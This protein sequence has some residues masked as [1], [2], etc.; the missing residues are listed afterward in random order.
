MPDF[1]KN[2]ANES[3]FLDFPLYVSKARVYEEIDP[4]FFVDASVQP[5]IDLLAGC[6]RTPEDYFRKACPYIVSAFD[7]LGDVFTTVSWMRTMRVYFTTYEDGTHT[8]DFEDKTPKVTS[9]GVIPSFPKSQTRF[10]QPRVIAGFDRDAAKANPRV[11]NL[12]KKQPTA[13]ELNLNLQAAML[14]YNFWCGPNGTREACENLFQI[15][16]DSF[17]DETGSKRIGFEKRNCSFFDDATL[18]KIKKDIETLVNL[19]DRIT[20]KDQYEKLT[21]DEYVNFVNAARTLHQH[22]RLPDSVKRSTKILTPF[23]IALCAE[24]LAFET[25]IKLPYKDGEFSEL[26]KG[27]THFSV[28]QLLSRFGFA[29]RKRH[30]IMTLIATPTKDELRSGSEQVFTTVNEYIKAK[31]VENVYETIRQQFKAQLSDLLVVNPAKH[32]AFDRREDF[33][34]KFASL[35]S[36]SKWLC[37]QRVVAQ[38]YRFENRKAALKNLAKGKI[39]LKLLQGQNLTKDDAKLIIA[40]GLPCDLIAVHQPTEFQ[41]KLAILEKTCGV[42]LDEYLDYF[43]ELYQETTCAELIKLD[44][45]N[46]CVHKGLLYI[47]GFRVKDWYQ[48]YKVD[49]YCASFK[50]YRLKDKTCVSSPNL[51]QLGAKRKYFP[52]VQTATTH[53]EQLPSLKE[54]VKDLYCIVSQDTD[55]AIIHL[56]ELYARSG[57]YAE[58]RPGE[59][60]VWSIELFLNLVVIVPGQEGNWG[61]YF[62]R[63]DAFSNA[64][65]HVGSSDPNTSMR[66]G[67]VT[68]VRNADVT[69]LLSCCPLSEVSLSHGEDTKL[70]RRSVREKY[71]AL[72]GSFFPETVEAGFNDEVVEKED[73]GQLV[74]VRSCAGPDWMHFYLELSDFSVFDLTQRNVVDPA[75]VISLVAS[76]RNIEIAKASASI[77]VDCPSNFDISKGATVEVVQYLPKWMHSKINLPY[78]AFTKEVQNYLLRKEKY[79]YGPVVTGLTEKE[80]LFQVVIG[81]GSEVSLENPSLFKEL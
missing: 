19:G 68:E 38:R 36:V 20:S 31:N 15:F 17:L 66:L 54:S 43:S 49:N 56:K 60:G 18:L 4:G 55:D 40:L 63:K 5:L 25:M 29:K 81:D 16:T 77:T 26:F 11:Q 24:F 47:A 69:T 59:K 9:D 48:F 71:R 44:E 27:G 67:N 39:A 78:I 7:S 79:F 70:A 6:Y 75:T 33:A 65:L 58:F 37:I 35:F 34:V 74:S 12:L 42:T 2:K 41:E 80:N 51:L 57:C 46:Y 8:L 28:D 21:V 32:Y 76:G 14:E 10:I 1:D 22:L 72:I 62:T 52:A 45:I 3:L 53:V 64:R 61:A 73:S 30:Q 23:E 50:S 13:D